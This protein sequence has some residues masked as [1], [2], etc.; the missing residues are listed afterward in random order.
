ME[1]FTL[2]DKRLTILTRPL[3]NGVKEQVRL[4]V[5][6]NASHMD[7]LRLQNIF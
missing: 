7:M 2:Y 3:G 5:L 4:S 1:N 6:A